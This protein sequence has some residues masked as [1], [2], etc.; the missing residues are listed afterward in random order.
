MTTHRIRV[1]AALALLCATFD[2]EPVTAQSVDDYRNAAGA[3]GCGLIPYSGL[4]DSC[5]TSQQELESLKGEKYSCGQ[6]LDRKDKDEIYKRIDAGERILA[7]RQQVRDRFVDAS[8]A[9]SSDASN[10]SKADAKPFILNIL[11]RIGEGEDNH[12]KMI[13]EA[14]SAIY[15]CRQL[16]Q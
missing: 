9:L 13:E 1:A 7:K 16:A 12:L 11:R 4:R 15:Y 6:D 10:D 8:R 3:A 14:K 5:R 2:V